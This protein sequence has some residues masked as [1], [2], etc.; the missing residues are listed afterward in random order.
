MK[1]IIAIISFCLAYQLQAQTTLSVTER[2]QLYEKEIAEG[3]VDELK[4]LKNYIDLITLCSPIDMGK[5]YRYFRE[6]V[7]YA[8]EKDQ[9]DWESAYWRRIAEVYQ[10]LGKSDSS[11]YCIDKAI[12]L[13]KGKGFD[14]EQCANYQVQGGAFFAGYEYEKALDAYL[15]ALELNEKDKSQKVAAQQNILNNLGIE[16]STYSMIADIYVKLLNYDKAI[17]YLLRAKKIM[18]D[19]PTERIAFVYFTIELNGMLASMYTTTK[20]PDKALPLLQKSYEMAVEK[21]LVPEI[22]LALCRLS[23]FYYTERKDYQQAFTFAREAQEISEKTSMPNLISSAEKSLTKACFGLKDYK[24]ACRYAELVLA[25]VEKEDWENLYDI[26]GYLI[27]MYALSGDIAQSEAY[28]TKY[29][30]AVSNLSDANLHNSLQEMEVKYDVQQKELE[31]VRQQSELDRQRTKQYVYIGGLILASILLLLFIYIANLRNKRNKI[32]V[33]SNATKD[34]FFSLISHDLKNP[35]IAQRDALQQLI[36]H[37]GEWD[38]ESLSQYY[39]EL[40]ISADGQVELLYNLLNWAQVQTGR[41]PYAP[42]QFDLVFELRSDMALAKNMAD[43]KGIS[44][45]LQMPETA[46]VTGDRHML[47]TVVRNL[48]TNAVKFTDNGGKVHLEIQPEANDRYR[49]SVV[50]TGTGMSREQLENLFHIGHQRSRTGTVGESGSG[51]GLN[52]CRELIEKHGSTIHV[53]SEIGKGSR[54]WFVL[55]NTPKHRNSTH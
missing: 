46:I 42:T 32:L 16:A 15:K 37:A 51:L 52:V 7:A 54:F 44:L 2:I 34:K 33:E 12:T 11:Y 25:H 24:T 47:T 19:N 27:M 17:D 35:A 1:Y 28:L 55:H 36:A 26:Y 9:L 6:A 4:M 22:V 43:R 39:E 49:I 38:T 45:D 31:I 10:D 50:D 13:I 21:E 41:M 14:Y 18:D 23:N 40:L 48:L 8:Q 29:N 53:Q 3:Q 5:T 30:E 20:Q